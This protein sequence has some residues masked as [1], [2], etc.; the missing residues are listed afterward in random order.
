MKGI[1]YLRVLKEEQTHL[2]IYLQDVTHD[3]SYS[4]PCLLKNE[5]FVLE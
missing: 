1:G 4:I 2:F 3:I 5:F